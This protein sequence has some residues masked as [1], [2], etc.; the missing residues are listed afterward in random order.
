MATYNITSQQLKGIGILN[1]FEISAGGASF[2]NT[3]SVELDGTDDDISC[4]NVT[5]FNGV[6]KASISVWFKTSNSTARY[7]IAKYAGSG[8]RQFQILVTEYDLN[9]SISR[10]ING[11]NTQSFN[12]KN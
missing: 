5:T 3:Y 8:D 4:G 6:N 10:K 9:G 11:G 1:S 2:T 12:R 7:L